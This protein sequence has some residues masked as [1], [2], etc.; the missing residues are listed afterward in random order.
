M[1]PPAQLVSD[2]EYNANV[3]GNHVLERRMADFAVWYYS[4][5]KDIPP[6]NLARRLE[7]QEKSTWILLELNALMIE[8]LREKTGSKSLFLPNGITVS[9]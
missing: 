6:E 9:P 4:N 2:L 1:M 7:F 8:R 3:S 5:V